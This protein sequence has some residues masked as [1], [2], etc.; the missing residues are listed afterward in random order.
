[1][2]QGA[3][4]YQPHIW[5]SSHI[6]HRVGSPSREGLGACLGLLH[7][8]S[9]SIGYVVPEGKRKR[10]GGSCREGPLQ[11]PLRSTVELIFCKLPSSS[12]IF[13]ERQMTLVSNCFLVTCSNEWQVSSFQP[14]GEK[15]LFG[16]LHKEIQTP[17]GFLKDVSLSSA[18]GEIS[19]L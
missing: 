12:Q 2:T 11:L 1:M 6:C 13:V 9:E 8:V 18:E 7:S 19:E 4:Q 15:L 3:I 16:Q 17:A 14:T 10:G 5:H